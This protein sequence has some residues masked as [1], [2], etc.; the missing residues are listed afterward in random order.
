MKRYNVV[1]SKRAAK[2][3]G[4]LSADVVEKIMPVI[5]S[6]Q[7]DPRPA[8]CK[9]LKGYKDLWRVRIGNY[10]VLYSISDSILL[11]DIREVGNRK[12]IYE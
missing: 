4:K 9:K 7:E 8:G 12:N 2:D 11:V 10:R 3:I 6:L 5:I 1:F